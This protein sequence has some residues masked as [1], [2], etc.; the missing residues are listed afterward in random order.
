MFTSAS[1]LLMRVIMRIGLAKVFSFFLLFSLAGY[2]QAA[3]GE[4]PLGTAHRLVEN[5]PELGRDQAPAVVLV[6]D[7]LATL[8]LTPEGRVAFRRGAHHQTLDDDTIRPG[9]K[10]LTLHYQG[11]HLYA[12]WWQ[13]RLDGG[14]HLYLRV[15]ADGG[16]SFQPVVILNS[17]TGV[18]PTFD[19]AFGEDGQVAVV[20]HDERIPK[21]GVYLNRSADGG[22]TWLKQDIRLNTLPVAKEGK[23]QPESFAVEPQLVFQGSTLV[24]TWKEAGSA[25][26]GKSSTRVMSRISEDGGLNWAP[27]VEIHRSE[28]DLLISEVLLSHRNQVF[29]VGFMA[30]QGL[31][32]YR[33]AEDEDHWEA[34]GALAGSSEAAAIS[35]VKALP[36]EENILLI[37]TLEQADKKTQVHVATLMT[38][39][40][41]WQAE[42]QRM[43][44]DKKERDLTRALNP[45]M[46]RLANGAVVAVWEDYRNIRPNI[47]LDYSPDGGKSWQEA[48]RPIE[49]PGRYVSERPQLLVKDEKLLVLFD[50]FHS[51]SRK[52]RDY[53]YKEFPYGAEMGM[54]GLPAVEPLSPEKKQQRLEERVQRF[55]NLRVE[56]KFAE[57]YEFFDPV[58]RAQVTRDQFQAQQGK[59]DY[60]SYQLRDTAIQGNIAE[61]VV[62][63]EFSIPETEIMGQK[64]SV[65]QKKDI[66]RSE[67]VWVYDNWYA[68]FAV[69]FGQRFLN[70]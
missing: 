12:L 38:T 18:L 50:R 37:H 47:Y 21:L 34:L 68:V 20:Y 55:W 57:T 17:D 2:G 61:A 16:K 25:P 58:F 69:P 56:G 29:L 40:G 59:I 7:E 42:T 5:V 46:A 54:A 14:K 10:Y 4:S 70:Y 52:R 19:M 45:D 23:K 62:E 8:Y 41:Q 60:Q 35:Q 43:D 3:L 66:I 67:W 11:E 32:A 30:G 48:P 36:Y 26:D 65:D 63:M 22:K 51:D 33:L 9:G 64:F 13:K 27:E 49:E 39:Q 1:F 44:R 6:N 24:A 28:R 15:S 53:V 31:L